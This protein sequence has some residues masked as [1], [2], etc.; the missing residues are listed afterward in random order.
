MYIAIQ[1]SNIAEEKQNHRY[2]KVYK[3]YVR[4]IM[5]EIAWKCSRGKTRHQF[6]GEAEFVIKQIADELRE[7]GYETEVYPKDNK[8]ELDIHWGQRG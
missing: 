7:V 5:R 6:R 1:A 3:R 8:F 2:Y 4:R